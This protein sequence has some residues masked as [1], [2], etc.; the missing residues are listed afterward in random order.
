M[1]ERP[2]YYITTAIAYTSGKPHIGN[3]YEIVL[4]DAIARY[5]RIQ[6]YDVFFQTGTDEHGQKIELKAE[7]AG[8]TPK[9]FVDNVS[10]E[11]QRIWDM[12]DTSYDKFIRTTDGYHEKQIQ[13][14]FKKLYDQGDIYKGHY[15]GMYCTPCESFF[16]E[17]QLVDGKCPDCGREVQPAKEEA[18]FFKMSKYADRLIEHINAHPEFIQPVSRKNEMM[19]NFLLPGLQDLCVSRTSFKWGI[20]VDFDPKHV[21]YVWLDALSNYITGIGY[22][23]GGDCTEQFRKDW[24]ADLHLIG[25]DIIRFHTIYWPIFLMALDLPLPKQIFGHPWLLQGDGK[26]SKSRGNVLYADELVDFFGVDAVRYFVLH[27]MPFENDGVITWELMVERLNSDL[28]NTLGN[29]VNRTVSMTN[30]YFGGV[31]SDKGAA[32]EVDGDLKAVMESTAKAVDAKMNDL[33]VADAMTEIFNLF[34]RCNK[35][36]DET[37]PWVL[38]KEEAKK[39]RLETVLWNLIQ[40][41]SAG[42]RLLE[43]FMPSTSRK[44]LS[45]LNEGHV[46]DKPEILFQR[47]DLK[48]VLQ[49]VEELHPPVEEADQDAQEEEQTV[50]DIEAKPE[51]TFDQFGAMQFQV[52]EIIA[53]EEVPKSKKLLCSKVKVGSQVKQIVSGIKAHYTPEDMVG[54]KVMVL[55]NLKPAKLAGVLSEGMLLCAEDADGVLSL[56]VPEKDMP[57]GAEIC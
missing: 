27:E 56:M 26:M 51:I 12:M 40:G 19:N 15:E 57:A 48:E 5:K 25:K 42:G 3:T 10:A 22:D 39:D 55:V 24:P 8:V 32:E 35:Y 34:K 49:K 11:I 29:L 4:A 23:C 18:Y 45:Q 38:A 14:I 2:K 17:S 36:I 21:V 47:L 9:E 13:K 41:I 1:S 46:T 6:G 53:C 37:M 54:K 30:K 43:A 28:A 31:V 33:R 44:I 16:T 52:G 50:I 20:P 7:E